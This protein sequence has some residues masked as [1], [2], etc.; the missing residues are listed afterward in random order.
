[1]HLQ[2]SLRAAEKI[3]STGGL[4]ERNEAIIDYDR[5]APYVPTNSILDDMDNLWR[6]RTPNV[7]SLTVDALCGNEIIGTISIIVPIAYEMKNASFQVQRKHN[8][9]VCKLRQ[10]NIADLPLFFS[11]EESAITFSMSFC[12]KPEGQKGDD[13]WE[14]R[15]TVNSILGHADQSLRPAAQRLPG[16][17]TDANGGKYSSGPFLV[18]YSS[19]RCGVLIYVETMH[20][21]NLVKLN[22]KIKSPVLRVW[23][24]AALDVSPGNTEQNRPIIENVAKWAFDRNICNVTIRDTDEVVLLLIEE[25]E[26]NSLSLQGDSL[27]KQVHRELAEVSFTQS[28]IMQI[29]RADQM[30]MMDYRSKDPAAMGKTALLREICAYRTLVGWAPDD[31]FSS[32]ACCGRSLSLGMLKC[33]QCRAVAFCSSSCAANLLPMHN[34]WC[35]FSDPTKMTRTPFSSSCFHLAEKLALDG[36]ELELVEDRV[37][38]LLDAMLEKRGNHEHLG[39]SRVTIGGSFAKNTCMCFDFDVDVV[40]LF[41]DEGVFGRLTVIFDALEALL[42][43]IGAVI[44]RRSAKS[45]KCSF[46]DVDFDVL[47]GVDMSPGTILS[48]PI[49]RQTIDAIRS[50]RPLLLAMLHRLSPHERSMASCS[51]T[52]SSALFM[53]LQPK[54]V[55][56]AVR[57]IKFMHQCQKA[58]AVDRKTFRSCFTA[59]GA[60]SRHFAALPSYATELIVVHCYR[61]AKCAERAESTEYLVRHYLHYI[62]NLSS[63]SRNPPIIFEDLY[64]WADFCHL[65]D[66]DT[67]APLVIVDPVN[68]YVDVLSSFRDWSSLFAEN[69]RALAALCSAPNPLEELF[70]VSTFARLRSLVEGSSAHANGTS[71][72]D[73]P[74]DWSAIR[75]N[76]EEYGRMSSM[77]GDRCLVQ[78]YLRR[79]LKD[80]RGGMN[81]PMIMHAL[82]F[83]RLTQGADRCSPKINWMDEAAN[84][85]LAD[86]HGSSF[87]DLLTSRSPCASLSLH[88]KHVPLLPLLGRILAVWNVIDNKG[89]GFACASSTREELRGTVHQLRVDRQYSRTGDGKSARPVSLHHFLMNAS[90]DVQKDLSKADLEKWYF[91]MRLRFSSST[92]TV[93][94]CRGVLPMLAARGVTHVRLPNGEAVPLAC[95]RIGVFHY[96]PYTW[97]EIAFTVPQWMDPAGTETELN[98]TFLRFASAN[99]K[100][101]FYPELIEAPRSHNVLLADNLNIIADMSIGQFTGCAQVTV[102]SDFDAYLHDT[103]FVRHRTVTHGPSLCSEIDIEGE[104]ARSRN[105]P[106]LAPTRSA[107]IKTPTF[108]SVDYISTISEHTN[109][110]ITRMYDAD[111]SAS[112]WDGCCRW[113][114]GSGDLEPCTRCHQVRY[115]GPYCRQ[116]HWELSH[117]RECDGR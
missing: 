89:H 92:L 22:S 113:C 98:P 57:V 41:R 99:A 84:E 116:R 80:N 59:R 27:C 78:D 37:S 28:F 10:L 77:T 103:E 107:S 14:L 6:T 81:D 91:R 19:P 58:A 94:F 97:H 46:R 68:P 101:G 90:L 73:G 38:V 9:I 69:R 108:S 115:C 56:R 13:F 102:H 67:Q 63:D 66:I 110:W 16:L 20:A 65:S 17:A 21:F 30:R 76:D 15:S 24:R 72:N 100:R 1:M 42:V 104:L 105:A 70:R 64:N 26:N 53:A 55:L 60:V 7:R 12:L 34:Q 43:V 109:R 50:Q 111:A 36:D 32:C 48:S 40:F 3:S 51:L 11:P 62:E 75:P 5:S 88:N 117:N 8:R 49:Q 23:F 86:L 25:L 44:V 54:A 79:T 18:A 71:N 39:Y 2:E 47:V 83:L 93:A 114:F 74:D 82:S 33:Q 87:T 61:T 31:H 95:W 52:E 96:D 4:S 106:R 85:L 112:W 45:I 35:K 29:T